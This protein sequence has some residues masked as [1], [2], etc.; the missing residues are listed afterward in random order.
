[1]QIRPYQA[2]DET[3]VVE[4]WRRCGLIR[5]VNDP[6]KDIRRKLQVSPDLFLVG[7]EGPEIVA[8]VMAGYEGHRG[9]INYVAVSPEH[10]RKGFGRQIMEEA[11]RLCRRSGVRRST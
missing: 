1:M 2:K 4:L 8:T 11:E 9:C 7:V 10:Q 3:A 6:G 5:P